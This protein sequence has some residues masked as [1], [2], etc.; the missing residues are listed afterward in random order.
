MVVNK[1]QQGLAYKIPGMVPPGLEDRHGVF[2]VDNCSL[3]LAPRSS[4]GAPMTLKDENGKNREVIEIYIPV[5]RSFS[6]AASVA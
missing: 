6:E 3:Y 2:C 1:A 5:A 4:T